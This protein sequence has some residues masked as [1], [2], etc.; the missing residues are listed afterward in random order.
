MLLSRHQIAGQIRGTKIANRCFENM[1]QIKYLGT[2][3]T[4]QNVIQEEIKNRFYSGNV[5]YHSVQNLLSSCLLSRN[6]KIAICKTIILFVVLH[7]CE[8]WSLILREEH[9][10]RVFEGRVLRRLFGPERDKVNRRLEKT[11]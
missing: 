8:N 1:A 5:C 10:L 9:R 3:I 11:A 7:A 6:I 4:S 2:T